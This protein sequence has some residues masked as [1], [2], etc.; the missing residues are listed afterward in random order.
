MSE[1]A[2]PPAMEYSSFSA[3]SPTCVVTTLE[4]NLEV[5]QKIGNIS[6]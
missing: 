1:F 4:I 5:P 3:S 6:T 2:I